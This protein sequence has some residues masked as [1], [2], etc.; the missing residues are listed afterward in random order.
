VFITTGWRRSIVILFSPLRAIHKYTPLRFFCFCFPEGSR[1]V[2]LSTTP[3]AT[4]Q[5][6]RLFLLP[7]SRLLLIHT[8]THR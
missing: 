2:C 4:E 5:S 1:L 3:P 8:H 7:T 6:S